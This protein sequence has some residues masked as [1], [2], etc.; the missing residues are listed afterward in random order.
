[1][2]ESNNR[3]SASRTMTALAATLALIGS[4]EVSSGCAGSPK[5]SML[6]RFSDPTPRESTPSRDSRE[7]MPNQES[8]NVNGTIEHLTN[9]L[10]ESSGAIRNRVACAISLS[11]PEEA[12]DRSARKAVDLL[13]NAL[14]VKA[15]IATSIIG[16]QTNDG[17]EVACAESRYGVMLPMPEAP[18][19]KM[20]NSKARNRE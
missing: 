2:K 12:G 5:S 3:M 19:D 15:S 1:M 4:G 7:S 9:S 6:I 18:T 16:T 10:V 17:I 13:K 20:R 8:R 14:S 11:S